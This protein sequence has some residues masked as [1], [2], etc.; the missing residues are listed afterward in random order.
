MTLL[1][2]FV[3]E[4]IGTALLI[5]LGVG[6]VATTLLTKSKGKGTGWLLINF[7]WGFAV[8]IGVY[9]AWKTGGHLNPAVTLGIAATGAEEFVPG[10]AITFSTISAY[11]AGQMVGAMVGAALAWLAYK[12]HYNAHENQA[13]ILGTFATGPEIRN[14][15]S[16]IITEAI[17]TFVLLAWVIINGSTPTQIGPLAVALVIVSIGASLGGPTGYAINPARDLGPR[18]MHAIL[19]IKGKGGSDWAYA[20]VPVVGPIIGAVLAGLLFGAN[21]LNI[22]GL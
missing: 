14:Y 17:G 2:I 13:E 12:D 4:M 6:V 18:I 5:T 8:M 15:T 3:S 7:G 20:W 19:P 21:T 9:G 11:I 16:N 22:A 1:E 10:V